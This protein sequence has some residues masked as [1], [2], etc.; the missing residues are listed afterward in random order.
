MYIVTVT[1]AD[2]G[3][4]RTQPQSPADHTPAPAPGPQ[5]HPTGMGTARRNL[6]RVKLEVSCCLAVFAPSDPAIEQ[7]IV[8]AGCPERS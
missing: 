1:A 7:Q 8:G 5:R 2:T 6:A 4:Q 3:F